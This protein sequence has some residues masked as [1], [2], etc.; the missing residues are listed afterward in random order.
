MT[1]NPSPRSRRLGRT[2]TKAAAAL[3]AVAGVTVPASA[4]HAGPATVADT[5]SPGCVSN[6]EY[7]Q[8]AIGQRL[9]LVRSVAGD[10]AQMNMRR[11]DSGIHSYQERLYT[12]CTPM[13]SRHDTLTARFMM[14]QGAW[15]ATIIDTYVGP[16]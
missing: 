9:S 16:E 1:Q 5:D 7:A 10:D 15:R 2:A 13:S 6:G 8:L 4:A 14:W 11:W 3:A 12:M